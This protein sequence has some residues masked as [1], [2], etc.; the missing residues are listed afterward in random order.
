MEISKSLLLSCLRQL[1]YVLWRCVLIF[2]SPPCWF[3]TLWLSLF[4]IHLLHN[5]CS[6]NLIGA[7]INFTIGCMFSNGAT[8]SDLWCRDETES[9]LWACTQ[10]WATR[11]TLVS[12]FLVMVHCT[13]AQMCYFHVRSSLVISPYLIEDPYIR[14]K[15]VELPFE[16]TK[17]R[18]TFVE[19]VTDI[20]INRLQE[21]VGKWLHLVVPVMMSV[22]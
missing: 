6:Y 4:A 16:V 10:G 8:I 15:V 12:R 3:L 5:A 20:N 14:P 9:L 13:T 11:H 1:G 21:V 17:K 19:L 7:T 22:I 18:I 2:W